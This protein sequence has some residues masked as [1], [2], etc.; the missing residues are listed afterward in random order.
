MTNGRW[1]RMAPRSNL[2][3]FAWPV[4]LY[5]GATECGLL[6]PGV[7]VLALRD[8]GGSSDTAAPPVLAFVLPD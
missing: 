7:E 6:E 8:H 4:V 2:P 5:A 3:A 1:E